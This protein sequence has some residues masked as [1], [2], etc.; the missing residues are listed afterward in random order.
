M[1]NLFDHVQSRP[2]AAPGIEHDEIAG[3]P[4][5]SGHVAITC[6]DYSLARY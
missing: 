1:M 6:I 3:L 4:G 2:G 5:G